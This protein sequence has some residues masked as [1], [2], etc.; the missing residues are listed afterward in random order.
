MTGTASVRRQ[1]TV[2]LRTT[3]TEFLREPVNLAL[4]V[5]LPPIVVASYG[6]MMAA[7]PALP[8]M[9][10]SPETMGAI[11]GAMFVAAFLPGVIGLFQVISARRADERLQLAGFRQSVLFLAR[12]A[13]VLLASGVAAVFTMAILIATVE[14]TAPVL[15]WAVL[16][17]VGMTYGL[18]GMLVGS[19]LPRELEGSLLLVFV[20]DLD[21]AM[22]SGLFRTDAL[23]TKLLP[24]HFP[25]D[26]FTAAVD[27]GTLPVGDAL[28][29]GTY[30]I[31]LLAVVFVVHGVLTGT[32]GGT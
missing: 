12:S 27:G 20:A 4:I 1:A 14:V 3:I 19:V 6:S 15:A 23:L 26:V 2:G 7:L 28:Y 30:A 31:V 22:A 32:G 18:V 5:V 8:G 10:A 17:L 25:H 13:A 9:A 16:V 11:N 24:L 21:E 29:A